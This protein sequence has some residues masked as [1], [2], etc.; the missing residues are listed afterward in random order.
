[1]SFCFN[2]IL[3]LVD[4]RR[5][6]YVAEKTGEPDM[7]F[8]P[9]FELSTTGYDKL[10]KLFQKKYPLVYNLVKQMENH[11]FREDSP[12]F[13]SLKMKSSSKY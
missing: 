2:G 9:D 13:Q 8:T 5:R 4:F 10:M 11:Y 12:L 3:G 6:D 7:D 1:M